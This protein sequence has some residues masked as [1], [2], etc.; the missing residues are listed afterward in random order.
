METG[1]HPE[2]T[3][4]VRVNGVPMHVPEAGVTV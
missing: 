2:V 4:T 3:V 1:T